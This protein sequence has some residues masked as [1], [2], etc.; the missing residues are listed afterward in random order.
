MKGLGRMNTLRKKVCRGIPSFRWKGSLFLL[1]LC[2]LLLAAS[3]CSTKEENSS[4]TEIYV[5]AAS[6]MTDC[7]NEVIDLYEKESDNHV[8]PVYEGSGT[9]K[10][11][12]SEGADC[13]IFISANQTYMDELQ[14]EGA[15]Q[16][17]TRKDLLGNSLTLIASAEKAETITDVQ[18]LLNDDIAIVAIGEPNDVPAGQ[19][20]KEMFENL[21]IWNDIQSKLVYAKNVRA[22]LE[23]VDGGDA[24]AGFVYRTDAVLLEKGVII[25]DVPEEYYTTVHYPAAIMTNASQP[26]AAADFYDFLKNDKV[27]AVFEKY[28]FTVL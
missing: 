22:V 18:S 10:K 2:I 23:Y 4:K 19:Y 27:K 5:F 28:G 15:V 1:L 14:E 6:S 24:D 20:A 21:G 8:I 26:K 3:G 11:Q 16:E 25:G 9:L 7:L 12:I 17:D 13:D